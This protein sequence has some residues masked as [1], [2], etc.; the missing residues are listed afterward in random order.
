M[1]SGSGSG[2]CMFV[3][4][5]GCFARTRFSGSVCAKV[6]QLSCKTSSKKMYVKYPIFIF[7]VQF[8]SLFSVGRDQDCVC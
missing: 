4:G 1:W 7:H 5:L 2:F 3:L 8:M 6:V